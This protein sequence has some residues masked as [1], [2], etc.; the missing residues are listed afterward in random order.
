MAGKKRPQTD[1]V[2]PKGVSAS[3][4]SR[5]D[6]AVAEA[7]AKKKK[8]A[9]ERKKQ[10]KESDVAK[11]PREARGGR[12]GARR[13]VCGELARRRPRR[14]ASESGRALTGAAAPAAARCH[15]RF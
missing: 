13:P 4:A 12:R 9:M 2:V 8:L 6:A 11:P 7:P 3:D 5:D 10:R 1:L 15:T 14:G